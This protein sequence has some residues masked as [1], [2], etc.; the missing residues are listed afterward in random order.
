MSLHLPTPVSYILDKPSD[1]DLPTTQLG[2]PEPSIQIPLVQQFLALRLPSFQ[3]LLDPSLP[4][5][6]LSSRPKCGLLK[7][8]WVMLMYFDPENRGG[9]ALTHRANDRVELTFPTKSSRVDPMLIIDNEFL[10][11][12]WSK[13]I[14]FSYFGK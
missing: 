2:L 8:S 1:I 9:N 14:G 10:Q 13:G 6:A 7:Y 4:F 3:Q 11:L 12:F 5:S